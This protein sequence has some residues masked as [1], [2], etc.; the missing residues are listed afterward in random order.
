MNSSDDTYHDRNQ[1]CARTTDQNEQ[2]FNRRTYMKLLGTAG[3]TA[4]T[5]SGTSGRV[6]AASDG[7][8][9]SGYGEGAY[10]GDSDSG[11]TVSTAEATNVTESAATLNG[12]LDD[13]DG[14]SSADCYFRWRRI[15]ADTWNTTATQTLSAI[16]SFSEDVTGL[17][18]GVD[19][20]YTA[21]AEASDG[22]TDTGTT[23]SF[24]TPDDPPAVTTDAPTNVSDSSAT[25]NGSLDDLGGASS[26]DCYFEWREVGASSWTTTATQTLSATG[27]FSEDVTGLSS[28]TDYEYR[29]VADASDGDADT[30][31]TLTF[32]TS[33]SNHAPTIDHYQVTEAGSPNP[34]AEITA[35]WVV[36]DADSNLAQVV[37]TVHDTDGLLVDSHTHAVSGS[38]ASGTDTFKIKHARDQIFDVTLAVTD[39]SGAGTSQTETVTE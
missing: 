20:E 35:D 25:L 32:T 3:I 12:S 28:G 7:Y 8:G 9:E 38:A 6:Q 24:S 31:S 5:V 10:G 36:G 17:E 39:E 14:A 22:D 4:A 37:V 26:V 23:V 29:A 18:D 15:G 21:V 19:Y 11:F 33:S 1:S 27:S 30:G 34:H 13:L 2:S 16:D